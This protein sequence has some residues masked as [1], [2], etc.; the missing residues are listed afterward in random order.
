MDC[1]ANSPE[2]DLCIGEVTLARRYLTER[3]LA[4]NR[5]TVR[6]VFQAFKL[7]R[8]ERVAGVPWLRLPLS[9]VER[10][11]FCRSHQIKPAQCILSLR[12]SYK[13][14]RGEQ[15][16]LDTG[17]YMTA[18]ILRL[19]ASDCQGLTHAAIEALRVAE[20][21]ALHHPLDLEVGVSTPATME[22]PEVLQVTPLNLT[23]RFSS[24]TLHPQTKSIGSLWEVSLASRLYKPCVPGISCQP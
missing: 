7:C 8:V 12:H 22:M 19:A 24:L 23:D 4:Q 1:V 17:L 2:S 20:R 13:A 6:F 16:R 9:A 15:V 5:R 3:F 14:G 18:N 11:T 21:L 10:C